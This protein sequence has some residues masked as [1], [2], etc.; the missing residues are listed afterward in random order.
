[1]GFIIRGEVDYSRISHF[2]YV[3]IELNKDFIKSKS[4]KNNIN[5]ED[6]I[7]EVFLGLHWKLE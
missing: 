5:T 4:N 7:N 1:M 2:I 3:I 6:A